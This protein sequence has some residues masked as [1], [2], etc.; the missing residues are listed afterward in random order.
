MLTRWPFVV[1]PL[2]GVA[3][4]CGGGSTPARAD[5]QQ[6]GTTV[7]CTGVDNN[8]FASGASGLQ[9][10]VAPQ[11]TVRNAPSSGFDGYCGDPEDRLGGPTI[12]LGNSASVNN[13]GFLYGFGICGQAIDVGGSSTVTNSGA[14][15]TN[16]ALAFG[17]STGNRAT[18]T[19]TGSITT[20][21]TLSYG[22]WTGDDARVTTGAGS[23][24]E[25]GDAGAIGIL[26]GDRSTVINGGRIDT[27]AGDGISVGAQSVVTNTGNITVTTGQIAAIR[28]T[29]DN[30]AIINR[31]GLSAINQRISIDPGAAVAITGANAIF[32][33]GGSVIGSYAG[34]ALT[35]SGNMTINNTGA[36]QGGG[37]ALLRDPSTTYSGGVI[38]RG[39]GS[40]ALNNS[41][42]IEGL[43]GRQA[44]RSDVPIQIDSRGTFNGN[45]T[46]SSGDDFVT[47]LS[48]SEMNGVLDGNGG[49][50]RLVV[51]NFGF[52]RQPVRNFTSLTKL[53]SLTWTLQ[54]TTTLSGDVFVS[55]GT[56]LV[57]SSARLTVPRVTVSPNATLTGNGRIDGAVS[58]GGIITVASSTAGA[59]VPS[60]FTIAGDFTQTAAGI[61]RLRTLV[62]GSDTLL[63]GGAA[64]LGGTLI[65]DS[66]QRY[67]GGQSFQIMRALGSSMTT[68][69]AFSAIQ[70]A[71]T[72]F[73]KPEIVSSA[74]GVELRLTKLP[75]AA[76][77]TTVAERAVANMF[78]RQTAPG[79]L[80]APLVAGFETG[81]LADAAAVFAAFAPETVPAVI[82]SG[83]AGLST[84]RAARDESLA[85]EADGRWRA[86]GT[87]ARRD[88]HVR[89]GTPVRAY[90]SV[91]TG[92]AAGADLAIGNGR[93]GLALGHLS[94]DNAFS[95]G[96]KARLPLT[97]ASITAVIPVGVFGLTSHAAFSFGFGTGR[98]SR[99]QVLQGTARGL[100]ARAT[101]T[102]W[103]F[104]GGVARQ[105]ALYGVTLAAHADF[106]YA[107]VS[108]RPFDEAM[109][110]GVRTGWGAT[111]SLTSDI[112]VHGEM[113]FGRL[114]PFAGVSW[115]QELL[116]TARRV[117]AS[118]IGVPD[119]GFTISGAS[120][121]RAQGLGDLGVAADV[122][123]GLRLQARYQT[124]FNDP[125]AGHRITAGAV[126][127]W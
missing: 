58:N 125:L 116:T 27:V 46:L 113:A 110:L 13:Q 28:G 19:N 37:E 81:T 121:R 71:T 84:L 5:C 10:T 82:A 107:R 23:S 2:W 12:S 83:F 3:V 101:T 98:V 15:F 74:A 40:V 68:T 119:S 104:D 115:V 18:I 30:I 127:R 93:I 63:I 106:A 123:P 16:Q 31:G 4:L 32:E 94:A 51:N 65:I 87:F 89:T 62:T 50:D 39:T 120:P 79:A 72:T 53:G 69:G 38:I 22:I 96:A 70:V 8:G 42:V 114:R 35:G 77:T 118:L 102:G 78:E 9:L 124:A 109:P 100:T 122:L 14:I 59:A 103:S 57:D 60:T 76:V 29:G 97:T 66:P 108:V 56:L 112:G 25:T 92:G 105:V 48:G 64:N 111:N 80:L 24:I 49:N 95:D 85:Q 75:Y 45:V 86:W 20:L 33:N 67:R 52:L 36:I 99:V 41:G 55:A 44:L 43:N 61:L 91:L 17:I 90:D 26:A 88:G 126:W 11:T 21:G 6:N 34:L 117:S 7:T 54:S 47:L 1:A 73:V